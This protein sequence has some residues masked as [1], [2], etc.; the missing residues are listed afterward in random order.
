LHLLWLALAQGP[1]SLAMSTSAHPAEVGRGFATALQTARPIATACHLANVDERQV[2]IIDPN[3]L[4][5]SEW[6]VLD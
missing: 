3:D 2:V 1:S 4:W 5:R 6:G